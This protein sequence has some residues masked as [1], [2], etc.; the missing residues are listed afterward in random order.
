VAKKNKT[1]A[2]Y[3]KELAKLKRENKK[4]STEL[5]DKEL[6]RQHI[7]EKI[8]EQKKLIDLLNDD[9]NAIEKKNEKNIS[10]FKISIEEV[11]CNI[12]FSKATFRIDQVFEEIRCRLERFKLYGYVEKPANKFYLGQ[13]NKLDNEAEGS[14]ERRG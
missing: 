2:D 13:L 4:L 3:K 7:M 11:M 6:L 1:I 14:R 10:I 5:N 9:I 12:L 8:G